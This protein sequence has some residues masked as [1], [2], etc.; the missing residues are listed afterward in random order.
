MFSRVTTGYGAGRLV[1]SLH[2]YLRVNGDT[3]APKTVSGKDTLQ[4]T[5][6]VHDV[7]FKI[8]QPITQHNMDEMILDAHGEKGL[9][10]LRVE[11]REW[12]QKEYENPGQAWKE[13]PERWK[14]LLNDI[15]EMDYTYNSRVNMHRAIGNV[16][17]E[18]QHNPDT[19]RAY[20]PIF[21]P[22]DA[23]SITLN[24]MIPCIIGYQF[25]VKKDDKIDMS[26][27]LRSCDIVNC[28]R[29]DIW[30]AHNLLKHVVDRVRGTNVGDITFHIM[31]LHEYESVP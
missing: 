17:E 8:G 10:F 1:D 21:S 12:F 29:N 11:G 20:L 4:S 3:Y 5:I 14:D 23:P 13:D 2:E 28:L 22:G 7:M 26:A 19:R 25:T 6:A 30:L 27:V 31:N 18:I 9:A 16:I 24:R 15:G